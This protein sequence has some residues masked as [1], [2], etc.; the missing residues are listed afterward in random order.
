MKHLK[1][2]GLISLISILTFSNL[3]AG[4]FV[5]VNQNTI[6][7]FYNSKADLVLGDSGSEEGTNILK[8]VQDKR[9]IIQEAKQD[10]LYKPV[11]DIKYFGIDVSSYQGEIDW[12]KVKEQGVDFVILRAGV[13]S[14]IDGQLHKDTYFEEYYSECKKYGIPV[15][16]YWFTRARSTSEAVEEADFFLDI[17]KD[18]QF[19]YPVCFDIESESLLNLSNSTLTDI[20]IAFCDH[21]EK[22]GY[23]VSIY[24][25][26]NWIDYHLLK[27]ELTLYDKWLA[28]WTD[29]PQYGSEFGGLW[30][31]SESGTCWGVNGDCDIDYS[32]KD[33]PAIMIRA[34]LNGF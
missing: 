26:P 14:S 7:T 22:A 2:L 25:N 20:T 3:Q 6:N 10:F 28:H 15:G 8:V 34:N 4:A 12:K 24:T 21:V 33:Y 1:K 29:I 30:Q 16:C 18:K 9:N 13:H 31:A 17:I 19:E 5:K 27:T 32:Y 23:Y 11:E